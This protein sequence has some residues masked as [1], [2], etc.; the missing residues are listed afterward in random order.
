MADLST[1][2]LYAWSYL[3]D[4]EQVELE[5]ADFEMLKVVVKKPDEDAFLDSQ[6]GLA[7]C[8]YFVVEIDLI[9]WLCDGEH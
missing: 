4:H 5:E 8:Q 9:G 3:A 7:A 2:L 6:K 1:V